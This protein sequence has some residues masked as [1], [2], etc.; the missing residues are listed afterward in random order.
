MRKSYLIC[1]SVILALVISSCTVQIPQTPIG[2]PTSQPTTIPPAPQ[3]TNPSTD[4]KR[5]TTPTLSATQEPSAWAN[6]HLTGKL[7]YMTGSL[8][9]KNFFIEIQMLDLV[10]GA[11]TSVF[12]TPLDAWLYY[13]S[14]SPDSKGLVMAYSPPPGE[15]GS[16]IQALYT[17]PLDGSEPPQLLLAPPT[18]NDGYIQV[19]WSPNG[20]YLYYTQVDNQTPDDPKRIYPPFTI[21][22]MKYPDGQP[23]L[24][25]EQAYWPRLSSDSKRLLYVSVDPFSCENKLM[26]A[27]PDGDNA[28]EVSLSG[29]Q[30]PNVKDAPFFAPD[31]GSIFFSGPSPTQS[32]QPN[33]LER[34]MGIGVAKADGVIPSDWWSVPVTGG[35]ITQKTSIHALGLYASIS[36]DNQQIASYSGDGIFIMNTDSSGLTWIVTDVGQISG[37]VCWIP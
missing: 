16:T 25:A 27:D 37:T 28:H 24:V 30:V 23:E 21:Y 10:T 17:M 26:I 31:G 14:V 13:V 29:P 34:I 5:N 35:E 11:T 36:P 4:S 20:E 32:Y 8:E 12:K 18:K 3:A 33:W 9:D 19:E 7:V 2:T 22:R 6:L 15:D 1:H